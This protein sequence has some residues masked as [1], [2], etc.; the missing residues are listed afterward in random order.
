MRI[1]VVSLQ[2]DLGGERLMISVT[3]AEIQYDDVAQ[4]LHGHVNQ[5][6]D[7]E[8][9]KVGEMHTGWGEGLPGGE[10]RNCEGRLLPGR[11]PP[12]GGKWRRQRGLG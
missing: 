12:S 2:Q 5:L 9:L 6:G 10:E 3:N 8:I 11:R 7:M 1:P 4:F